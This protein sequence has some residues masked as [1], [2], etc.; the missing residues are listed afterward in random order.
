MHGFCL[1]PAAHCLRAGLYLMIQTQEPQLRLSGV[2]CWGHRAGGLGRRAG[3]CP[4]SFPEGSAPAGARLGWTGTS[5]LTASQLIALMNTDLPPDGLHRVPTRRHLRPCILP[6]LAVTTGTC[7]LGNASSQ[8]KR[9]WVLLVLSWVSPFSIRPG[10][11]YLLHLW[12]MLALK[13]K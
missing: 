1:C 12:L 6:G 5:W 4:L 13:N 8:D 3:P 11:S 7:F 9:L 2:L 10:H